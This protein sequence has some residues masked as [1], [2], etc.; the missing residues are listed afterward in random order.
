[1][2]RVYVPAD[3]NR[4]YYRHFHLDNYLTIYIKYW[5]AAWCYSYQWVPFPFIYPCKISHDNTLFRTTYKTQKKTNAN[6]YE[7]STD[8]SPVSKLSSNY[9]NEIS[10]N[11]CRLTSPDPAQQRSPVSHANW[12]SAGKNFQN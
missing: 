6:N 2:V 4:T 11:Q 9:T 12:I 1:M 5:N 10:R 3:N 8:I 7:D